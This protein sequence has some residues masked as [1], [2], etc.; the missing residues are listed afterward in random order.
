M[1]L[2]AVRTFVVAAEVGQFQEAAAELAVTQ[3]AVSKRIAA[4]ERTLGVRLFTRTPR[5]AELTIDGQAFLPHARELLRVAE[6]AVASVRVGSRPL[7]VD[8]IASRG[9]A[10]GLMRDFHRA[11]PEVELDV[12]MLHDIEAAVSAIRSGV[13]DA[14]FRAVAMPGRALPE[15]V[16]SVRVLDESLQLFTGPAHAL[17]DARSVT[18]AQLVGHRIWMPGIV[19]GTEWGAYY[20]DLVAAFGLTIEATGPNFGSDALLDTV[21]DTPALATFMGERTRLVWPA[22]YGL[23]R[24]PVTDPEPVYPHSLLWRRDNPHPALAT[25]RAHLAGMAGGHGAAGTWVP[26][27][28]IQR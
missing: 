16:E 26:G 11:Y 14:T 1:D 5:G 13:I 24:I 8:V 21:A 22:G 4:L 15:D 7:R 10:S 18:M 25:L 2:D 6:R 9:A 17:A 27:W 20:D 23:R 19:P 3:Q 12:V 28:V